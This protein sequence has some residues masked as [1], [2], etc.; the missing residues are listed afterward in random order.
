MK[1]D[2]F[3]RV[4]QVAPD[5][6]RRQS[7]LSTCPFIQPSSTLAAILYLVP[8]VTKVVCYLLLYVFDIYL[9]T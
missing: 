9:D 8:F 4:I 2:L 3:Y 5:P 1:A 6:T 7:Q